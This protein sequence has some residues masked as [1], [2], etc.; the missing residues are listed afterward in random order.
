LKSWE[1]NQI[2]CWVLFL[3]SH[4]ANKVYLK[5]CYL[6]EKKNII[7]ERRSDKK[8]ELEDVQESQTNIQIELEPEAITLN[9]QPKA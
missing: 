5:T 8:I 6:L 7:F 9:V 2:N 1:L 3:L 4:W